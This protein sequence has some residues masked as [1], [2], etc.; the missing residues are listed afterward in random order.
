[1]PEVTTDYKP[2]FV[3][4]PESE[5]KVTIIRDLPIPGEKPVVL[6]TMEIKEPARTILYE[7]FMRRRTSVLPRRRRQ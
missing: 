4:H 7:S 3:F 5:T 6:H 1:M 2:V